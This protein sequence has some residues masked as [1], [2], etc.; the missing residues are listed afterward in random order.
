MRVDLRDRSIN[1]LQK[2]QSQAD[3]RVA[4]ERRGLHEVI[5]SNKLKNDALQLKID[6][7]QVKISL[8]KEENEQDERHIELRRMERENKEAQMEQLKK[9]IENTRKRIQL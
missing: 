1:Q 3:L 5:A 9:E 2:N 4:K 7:Q 8:S 6:R